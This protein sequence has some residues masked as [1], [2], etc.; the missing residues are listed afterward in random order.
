MPQLSP[1]K[2]SYRLEAFSLQDFSADSGVFMDQQSLKDLD[3]VLTGDSSESDQD[4]YTRTACRRIFKL[5]SER[6]AEFW[7]NVEAVK[8]M[9]SEGDLLSMDFSDLDLSNKAPSV[10]RIKQYAVF[11]QPTKANNVVMRL[12]RFS[13]RGELNFQPLEVVFEHLEN[14][15]YREDL[16]V[17]SKRGSVFAYESS[18]SQEL[19]L[20]VWFSLLEGGEEKF[21][22]QLRFTGYLETPRVP[23][24]ESM[25]EFQPYHNNLLHI[26]DTA[27][28][29]LTIKPPML[30][31]LFSLFNFGATD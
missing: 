4:R 7:D 26:K 20:S 21:L 25:K 1:K 15:S 3:F 14:P 30:W 22:L 31:K 28:K 24:S 8:L 19:R 6:A 10:L 9:L 13:S 18:E 11:D 5:T 2:D 12:V 27:S 16:V 23:E 17:E 29:L